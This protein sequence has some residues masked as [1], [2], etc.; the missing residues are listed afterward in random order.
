MKYGFTEAIWDSG[1]DEAATILRQRA[2]RRQTIPYRDL[3][4][5]LTTISIGYHDPAMDHFLCDISTREYER[6]RPLLSV[7]VVHKRGAMEPGSGFYE[8]ARALGFDVSDR[9]A[10]WIAELSRTW[11]F[12][13]SHPQAA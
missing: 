12:W 11:D 9:Q 1:V 7:L 13:N 2:I 6:G 4:N 5:E 8:L 3:S 10:F